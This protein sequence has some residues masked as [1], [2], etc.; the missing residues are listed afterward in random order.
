MRLLSTPAK[1]YADRFVMISCSTAHASMLSRSRP[2]LPFPTGTPPDLSACPCFPLR[3]G[4]GQSNVE[5]AFEEVNGAVQL[6][7]AIRG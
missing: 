2:P 4:A 6:I 3:F 5:T 1:T 7:A